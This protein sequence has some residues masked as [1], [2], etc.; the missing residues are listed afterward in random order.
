VA[1]HI[2]LYPAIF[3]LLFVR[4]WRDWKGNLQRLAGLG[5][6]NLA[7]LFVL[8]FEVFRDFLS[9]IPRLMGAL[10]VRPYNHSVK[11]FVYG[12]ADPASGWGESLGSF[13]PWIEAALMAFFFLC[14]LSILV[15]A[16]RRNAAGIDYDLMLACTIGALIIPSVS[17][18]YKL[19]LIAAPLALSLSAHGVPGAGPQ[20]WLVAALLVLIGAT[21]SVTLFPFIDRPAWLANSLPMLLIILGGVTLLNR[22]EVRSAAPA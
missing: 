1:V 22:F 9:A 7:L 6:L 8:G 17:I 4:D 12:L 5:A 18:D 15:R 3:V 2:K 11:S 20:K 14:L 21:Y 10:W 16:Y 13:L 19:P